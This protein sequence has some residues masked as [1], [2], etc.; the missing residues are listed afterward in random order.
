[1]LLL[2]RQPE[3]T[4]VTEA[5][6]LGRLQRE[7][8]LAAHIQRSMLPKSVP[9]YAGYSFW[10]WWK[11]DFPVGGDMYDYR[12]LPGGELFILAGDVAG[13]GI[14]AALEMAWLAGM[15][16]P[17]LRETGADP[18]RFLTAA[19]T[20][21]LPLASRTARFVTLVALV[22][23]ASRHQLRCASAAFNR[24]VLHKNEGAVKNLFQKAIL[25][26]FPLGVADEL[27]FAVVT[28]DIEPGDALM[29]VSDG[30]TN[31]TSSTGRE[32]GIERCCQMLARMMGD[33]SAIG[34]AC[35]ADLMAFTGGLALKDDATM[36]CF[37]RKL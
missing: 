18:G 5:D 30:V 35:L 14:A 26:G 27:P 4:V 1:M 29:I 31:A 17:L 24:G 20:L 37:S 32:Y 12:L 15:V 22:L 28:A 19:N 16:E 33:A 7:L 34:E 3:A 25:S 13:K 10:H 6:Q 8:E 11:P 9:T 23:D 21:L 2:G 36:L